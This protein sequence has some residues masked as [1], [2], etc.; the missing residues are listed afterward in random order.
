[1]AINFGKS[2]E[3]SSNFSSPETASKLFNQEGQ[4]AESEVNWFSRIKNKL[5]L[6]FKSNYGSLEKK[7]DEVATFVEEPEVKAEIEEL[8]IEAEQITESSFAKISEQLGSNRGGWYE[9]SASKEKF[10][11]K[12]YKNFDQARVEYIANAIYKKLGIN[13]VESEL[14][15]VDNEEAIASSEISGAKSVYEDEVKQSE[16][17]RSGF[18]AD[19]YL[20]NWDVT[21]ASYDNLVKGEDGKMYRIDNGGSLTFRARGGQKEYPSDQIPELKNMRDL[22]FPSGR[23][24]G[25]ITEEN[26]RQQA[27]KLINALSE[28]DIDKIIEQ[29]GCSEEMAETLKTGLKGRRQFL[30]KHFKIESKE[31]K[32]NVVSNIKEILE[33]D[34][35]VDTIFDKP[36]ILSQMSINYEMPDYD[37]QELKPG[38]RLAF[39]VPDEF[40]NRIV[41]DVILRHRKGE[42]YRVDIGADRWDP[43]GAY[44]RVELHNSESDQWQQWKDPKGYK[45]DKFAEPRSASSPEHEVLH[46]WVAMVGEIKPDAIRLTNVGQHEEYSTA[47]VHGIE[48]IFFP[49]E[50]N[51]KY[52][53]QV[54]CQGTEFIDLEKG[55]TLPKYGG[56]SNTEGKY[57]G[58]V[59]LNKSRESLYELAK[60]AGPEAEMRDGKLFIKLEPGKELVQIEVAV[61]DTEHLKEIN[62]KTGRHT[63]L[64]YAK[65]W[66]GIKRANSGDIEWFMENINIP[67]QGIFAGGPLSDSSLIQA[68]DELIVE[69]RSD[70]AYLMGWRLAY[71]EDAKSPEEE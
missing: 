28:E 22:N 61:G 39:V 25:D 3:I 57:I 67:P 19:A 70:T 15:T 35:S 31:N 8:K 58:A 48:V 66:A 63:R 10:Y 52:Q 44:T 38:R 5:L 64:G 1:M 23:V 6:E 50:K 30:I 54:Y 69:A 71:K 55:K 47:N 20:A 62:P 24:F 43:H 27:E 16:E 37:G 32:E 53:E 12:F 33:Q 29:S 59:A 46:D 2:A 49:E 11:V 68:G 17:I 4:I 65:L 21:G 34:S 14:K 18:V 9:D 51:V 45:T 40:K 42:K 13:T 41:R 26:M 7:L 60:D 36:R 56:G